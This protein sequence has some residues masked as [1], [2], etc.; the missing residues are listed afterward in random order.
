MVGG[1]SIFLDPLESWGFSKDDCL[2]TC[3]FTGHP[4]SKMSLVRVRQAMGCES[5][6]LTARLLSKVSEVAPW[7][8]L[9]GE[10]KPPWAFG[11]LHENREAQR[12]DPTLALPCLQTSSVSL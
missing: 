6:M 3:T 10:E 7:P 8:D 4:P 1:P 2:L 9:E 5:R 11:Y 12:R